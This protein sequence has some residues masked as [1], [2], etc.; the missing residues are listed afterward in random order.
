MSKPPSANNSIRYVKEGNNLLIPVQRTKGYNYFQPP[1]AA[2]PPESA[3]TLPE[4]ALR[5]KL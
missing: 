4:S 5:S 3:A 1:S 2:I